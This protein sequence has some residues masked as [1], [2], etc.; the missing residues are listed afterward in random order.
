M[1]SNLYSGLQYVEQCFRRTCVKELLL[2]GPE[3]APYL[4]RKDHQQIGTG[5]RSISGARKVEAPC[6]SIAH[7]VREMMERDA[8]L[9]TSYA[10]A[11]NKFIA[12]DEMLN[13][14]S[15]D[16]NSSGNISSG[17]SGKIMV[18][19]SFDNDIASSKKLQRIRPSHLNCS[20]QGGFTSQKFMAWLRLRFLTKTL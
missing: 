14:Q 6:L 17:L 9:E 7:V 12:T 19:E 10:E 4:Q 18:S 1:A 3:N 16:D 2:V 5:K 20:F 15:S 8:E 11:N 13:K